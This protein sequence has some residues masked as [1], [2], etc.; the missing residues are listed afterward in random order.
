MRLCTGKHFFTDI[1]TYFHQALDCSEEYNSAGDYWN[2]I[3]SKHKQ[4]GGENINVFEDE[5]CV[6]MN[7][8][9]K[10]K[11]RT[12]LL[13]QFPGV[14]FDCLYPKDNRPLEDITLEYIDECIINADYEPEFHKVVFWYKSW[15]CGVVMPP[16]I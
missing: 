1:S 2:G 7:V 16:K 10:S 13:F 14:H 12:E 11:L 4:V 9:E 8:L 15:Q 3:F 5:L 6:Y